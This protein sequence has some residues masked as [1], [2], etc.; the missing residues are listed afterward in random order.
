MINTIRTFG[1][2]IAALLLGLGLNC[3]LAIAQPGIA[4]DGPGVTEPSPPIEATRAEPLPASTTSAASKSSADP[5]KQPSSPADSAKV[6]TYF[7]QVMAGSSRRQIILDPPATKLVVTFESG[8][9]AVRCG[10]GP[11]GM[12]KGDR[13]QSYTCILGKPLTIERDPDNAITRFWAQ[14]LSD[15]SDVRLRLKSYSG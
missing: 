15:V 8:N 5:E 10:V 13:S 2:S 7:L 9:A 11:K 4:S 1:L 14:D 3:Q 6:K 12:A